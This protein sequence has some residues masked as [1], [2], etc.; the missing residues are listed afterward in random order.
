MSVYYAAFYGGL[1]AMLDTHE[2]SYAALGSYF[3][4]WL[5]H[6]DYL[7]TFTNEEHTR[8]VNCVDLTWDA[9][10]VEMDKQHV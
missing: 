1:V 9:A 7:D 2:A 5:S 10:Q 3:Q 8:F 4:M 6:R